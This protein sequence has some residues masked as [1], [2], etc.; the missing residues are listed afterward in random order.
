MQVWSFLCVTY[1]IILSIETVSFIY[2]FSLW[3]K[4]HIEIEMGR[5]LCSNN[6]TKGATQIETKR[7]KQTYWIYNGKWQFRNVRDNCTIKMKQC[8]RNEKLL[9]GIASIKITFRNVKIK[10]E[11]ECATNWSAEWKWW[12]SWC[13]LLEWISVAASAVTWFW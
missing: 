4:R 13:V 11:I 3:Y 1:I 6:R 10:T 2:L 5:T 7:K 9:C 12:R 8:K